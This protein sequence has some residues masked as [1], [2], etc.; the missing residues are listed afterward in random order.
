MNVFLHI[1]LKE[2]SGVKSGLLGGHRT[3]PT[4]LIHLPG[5]ATPRTSIY[6]LYQF[7]LTVENST[8]MKLRLQVLFGAYC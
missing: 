1:A 2:S 7:M 3:E 4:L 5:K 6:K 8:S